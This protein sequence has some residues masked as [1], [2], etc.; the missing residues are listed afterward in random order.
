MANAPIIGTQTPEPMHPQV[1]KAFH[2]MVNQAKT[3]TGYDIT[4]VRHRR[5]PKYVR[6]KSAITC[7][8]LAHMKAKAVHI[9]QL[10]GFDNSAIHHFKT[11]H[12]KRYWED[13]EYIDIY[14][15]LEQFIKQYKTGV[16]QRVEE[17][18]KAC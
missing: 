7:L 3:L 2:E 11:T 10:F 4:Y 9:A 5:N 12:K 14:D 16:T 18:E 15:K 8:L 17:C 13:E 1:R 6:I